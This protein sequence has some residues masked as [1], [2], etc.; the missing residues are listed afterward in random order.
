MNPHKHVTITVDDDAC[1][2]ILSKVAERCGVTV[3]VAV[4]A[5]L[6][7]MLPDTTSPRA[8]RSRSDARVSATSE[9]MAVLPVRG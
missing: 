5:R 7:S 3:Q 9:A 4:V 2:G 6:E 8:S 1:L